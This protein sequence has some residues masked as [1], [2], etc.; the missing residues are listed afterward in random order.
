MADLWILFSSIFV[1]AATCYLLFMMSDPL[2]DIGGRLGK[3]LHVPEDV[4]AATFQA[5]ATS[6]PEI[7]MA[8]LAATAFVTIGW[9]GLQDAEKECSGCL[10]M[11]FSAMDNLLGIGCLGIIFMIK[12]GTVTKDEVIDVAP[13]VKVGLLF[14]ILASTCLCLFIIDGSINRIEGWVLMVIGIVFIISQFFIPPFLR[15]QERIR[16]ENGEAPETEAGDDDE[17]D[18]EDEKPM[19]ESIGAWIKDFVS[20]GFLYAFLVFGLIVFVRECLSAT[21]DLATIGWVSVGGILLAF[22]SYVSSFPEFMMT[23]RFAVSNKKDALLAMLFGSNVIDLAFAGFRPIWQGGTMEVYTTGMYPQ[24]L[25]LYLWT[26]PVL[27]IATLIGLWTKKI[28]YGLAYP[29]VVFYLIYIISGLI[30]L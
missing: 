9:A 13:S 30:L 5:M 28:K 29:L 22:T 24:I 14:Y 19:P 21:F 23:Y 26:L 7:V 4:V 11:C 15:R 27:A 1:L 25:P 16:A 2:E 18:D 8:I 20:H 6:G 12:R 17:E 3:L 10:N